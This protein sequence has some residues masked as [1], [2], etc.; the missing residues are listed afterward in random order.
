LDALCA[1]ARCQRVVMRDS[2][3]VG[4][5]GGSEPRSLRV[6]ARERDARQIDLTLE[7]LKAQTVVVKGGP[8]QVSSFGSVGVPWGGEVRVDVKRLSGDQFRL[9]ITESDSASVP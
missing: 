9:L 2:I 8:W 3:T 5:A 4:L 1:E 6:T 7:V